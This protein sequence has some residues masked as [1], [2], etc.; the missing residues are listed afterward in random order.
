MSEKSSQKW[1]AVAHEA[2]LFAMIEEFRPS[3]DKIVSIVERMSQ[4]GHHF[5]FNG[6]NQHIQKLRKARDTSA[7]DSSG[8]GGSKPTTPRKATPRKTPTSG[9]G[10]R[11]LEE[12]EDELSLDLKGEYEE[13][14]K[15]TPSKRVKNERLSEVPDWKTEAFRNGEI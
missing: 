1:N 15:S 5:T 10:K 3:K 11:K 2:L 8:D 12:E 7:L 6:V 4:Q 13:E 14:T 9:R